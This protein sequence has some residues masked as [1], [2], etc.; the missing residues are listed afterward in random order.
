M[1]DDILAELLENSMFSD[2]FYG[3]AASEITQLR[4][5]IDQIDLALHGDNDIVEKPQQSSAAPAA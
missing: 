5:A 1:G 3:R 2:D 4:M